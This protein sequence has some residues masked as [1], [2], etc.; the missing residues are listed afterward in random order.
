MDD[1]VVVKV[2]D[3]AADLPHEQ[4]AVG[5]GQVEVV[6]GDPLEQLAPVQVLHHQDHLARGLE[7]V[8]KPV[9]NILTEFKNILTASKI[10]LTQF[11]NI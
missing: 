3:A 9:K 8:Y 10:I 5:L 4:A 2:L 1:V 7:R 6:R 11:K